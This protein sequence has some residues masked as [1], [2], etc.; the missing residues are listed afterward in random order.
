MTRQTVYL[1]FDLAT[2]TGWG[3]LDANGARIDSGWKAF[4]VKTTDGARW[5]LVRRWMLER[6]DHAAEHGEPVVGYELVRRHA[7]TRAAHVYGAFEAYLQEACDARDVR[8]LPVTVQHVKQHATGKGNADKS[9]MVLAA[10][11]RWGYPTSS[12]KGHE[13][14]ADALHIASLTLE[15][16]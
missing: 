16:A 4:P 3:L 12:A 15:Q 5:G 8:L 7:A 14:E 1:G 9:A 11:K 2:L 6:L 10:R 13:D